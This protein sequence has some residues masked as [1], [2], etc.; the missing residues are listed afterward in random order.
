[1]LIWA[2][3]T[4]PDSTGPWFKM[5]NGEV[6]D[7]RLRLQGTNQRLETLPEGVEPPAGDKRFTLSEGPSEPTS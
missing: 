3:Y 7:D 2:R 6:A 1:M 5:Y 4:Y